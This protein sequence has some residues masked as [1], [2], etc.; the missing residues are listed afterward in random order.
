MNQ[1]LLDFRN[2]VCKR[3]FNQ[4]T[5]IYVEKSVFVECFG[6]KKETKKLG[7][8]FFIKCTD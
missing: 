6:E 8:F 2:L 4:I 3:S 1:T 5:L 7:T